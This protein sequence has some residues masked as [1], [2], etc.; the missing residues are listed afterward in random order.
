MLEAV[1]MLVATESAQ[2]QQSPSLHMFV[3]KERKVVEKETNLQSCA[4]VCGTFAARLSTTM[5]IAI[6]PR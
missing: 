3:V 2:I 6:D 1:C 5:L 4:V